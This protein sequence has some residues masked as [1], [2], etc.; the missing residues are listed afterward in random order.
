MDIKKVGVIGCGTMGGGIVQTCA[1]SGYEVR[2]LEVTEPL[3]AKG[4]A[5]IDRILANNVK[6]GKITIQGKQDIQN[7]INGTLDINSFSDCDIVIEAATE[8]LDVK[9]RI[10]AALDK[11]CP[12]NTILA[13]NTS[14]LSIIDMAI[15]TG[16][17]D[18]V[19]GLH[20]M[21]PVPVM[22]LLEIIRTILTGEETL[23]VGRAFGLSLGKTIVETKDE[24]GFI[25]N[26]LLMPFIL[27]SI[28]MLENGFA[29]RD[30][31][32]KSIKLGLNHPLGPLALADIIGLDTVYFIVSAL[33]D[34]LKDPQYASP[35]ML[36][37]MVA[38]NWLGRKSGK[39][40]YEYEKMV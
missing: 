14:C 26:R 18:K 20:F 32:D 39:G 22:A 37:K 16:R 40:F 11:I 28:R 38:A 19:L 5:S 6:K 9:K 30:D 3:L 7:R 17:P 27:N 36:K 33:Y 1:Q 12:P 15:V 21:N 4:L 10:F 31:I 29:S 8:K 25:A 24:P 2:V 34:E 13:T 35:T 23:N